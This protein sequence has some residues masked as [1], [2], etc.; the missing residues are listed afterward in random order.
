MTISPSPTRRALH[1]GGYLVLR[2]SH[3]QG[4]HDGFVAFFPQFYRFAYT[5]YLFVVFY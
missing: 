1:S 3:S 4:F 5:R 2:Y